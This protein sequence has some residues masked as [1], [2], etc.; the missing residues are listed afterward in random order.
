MTV[1]LFVL[2]DSVA[3]NIAF[4]DFQKG[5]ESRIVSESF[6]AFCVGIFNFSYE[7]DEI[8]VKISWG[9]ISIYNRTGW[10]W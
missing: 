9:L 2:E 7:A 3:W 8:V 10:S 5:T 4:M 6:D 1:N